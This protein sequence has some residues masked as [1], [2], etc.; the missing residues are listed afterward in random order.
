MHIGS[1]DENGTRTPRARRLRAAVSPANVMSA[2]ALFV[3][4]GG[5]AY[6]TGVLPNGSVGNEQLRYQAVSG[7]KI[8]PDAI[9][10]GKVK[11]G[12]LRARD[13]KSD[14]L[15]RGEAGATGAPGAKGE[16]G[17][18][19]PAGSG[20]DGAAGPRGAAGEEGPVGPMGP[21][22]L[23]G[24]QGPQGLQGLIGPIGPAGPKGD[25]GNAGATGAKG[26]A[27][28]AGPAGPKG[29]T[30]EAGPA[31]PKGDTGEAGPPGAKGDK[32]DTG[33]AGPAGT[34][35]TA[36][37][38]SAANTSGTV[39]AVLLGGTDVP[40]PNG[41]NIGAGITVNGSNT[42]WTVANAGRYRITYRLRA[43]ASLLASSRIALNGSTVASLDY[44]PSTSTSSWDG[45]AI[46]S[47]AAGSTLSL[48]F[49]GL[50]GAVTLQGGAGAS[51][52][53]ERVS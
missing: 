4:L 45:D 14:E 28:D 37:S 30:G 11:D 25:T 40:L 38:A 23:P 24:M 2:T 50:L 26:D 3:A 15:P 27:G 48:Q 39:I 20:K 42:I 49:Y 22:G 12:S 6:A 36:T 51:L 1:P 21:I 17:D 9:T 43:T 34:G 47:L 8:A 7:T 18:T 29:D 35:T 5:T 53:I 19:G 13:F 32:G 44:V 33:D 41:Q 10:T 31:G 52:V 16:K 46:V